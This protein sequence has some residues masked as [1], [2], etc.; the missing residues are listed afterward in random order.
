M[1]ACS[2]FSRNLRCLHRSVDHFWQVSAAMLE[3]TAGHL[4]QREIPAMG[5]LNCPPYVFHKLAKMH[6]GSDGIEVICGEVY[7]TIAVSMPSLPV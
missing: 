7:N 6:G 1:P 2:E 4:V 3:R 5:G